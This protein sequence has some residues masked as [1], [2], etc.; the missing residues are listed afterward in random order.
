MLRVFTV[1]FL[2][3][4]LAVIVATHHPQ[5]SSTPSTRSSSA[6]S[7]K[8]RTP[9]D[10][11]VLFVDPPREQRGCWQRFDSMELEVTAPPIPES[12]IAEVS[13]TVRALV[14]VHDLHVKLALPAGAHLVAQ[15]PDTRS[16]AANEVIAGTV[17]VWFPPDAPSHMVS[18]QAT[19]TDSSATS[20]TGPKQ[21]NPVHIYVSERDLRLPP[22][23]TSGPKQS[24]D[25]S[26]TYKKVLR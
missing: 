23:V 14:G 1:S 2:P 7:S 4:A 20:G 25:L 19:A 11:W 12:G 22:I 24:R 21:S 15:S 18:L 6:V 8:T 5:D 17:Y 13:Y 16:V 3:T 9:L 26:A 10:E